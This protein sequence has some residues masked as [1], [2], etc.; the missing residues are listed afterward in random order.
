MIGIINLICKVS[1]FTWHLSFK[2]KK[3][4]NYHVLSLGITLKNSIHSYL[5]SPLNYVLYIL[6]RSDAIHTLKH[7]PNCM[8]D[9]ISKLTWLYDLYCWTGIEG[10]HKNVKW[11]LSFHYYFIYLRKW[12][13]CTRKNMVGRQRKVELSSNMDFWKSCSQEQ[14]PHSD[15]AQQL[16]REQLTTQEALC[17]QG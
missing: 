11:I 6:V 7:Q 10:T 8:A 1:N 16:Y 4:T 15:L 3:K 14:H 5:K 9:W 12:S 13:V 2:K 17:S